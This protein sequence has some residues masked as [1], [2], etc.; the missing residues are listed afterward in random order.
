MRRT[1][2]GIVLLSL[3]LAATACK[4]GE[5]NM[6]QA[7]KD[8]PVKVVEVKEETREVFLEYI[9]TVHAD[10]VKKLSFKSSGRISDVYVKKGQS[11]RKGD[12]LA[13]LDTGDLELA[14]KASEAQASAAKAQYEKAL[15]GAT[16][17]DINNAALNLKKAREAYEFVKDN[18]VKIEALYNEGAVS[19]QD[20]D[21]AKL[22]LDVKEAEAR[23]A[24]ELYNQVKGGAR[25]E[26]KQALLSQYRQA[27][28]DA[29]HKR[30]L[31][32]DAVMR[33]GMDGYVLD[34]LFKKD[35]MAAAGYP[36][37]VLRGNGRIIKVG[38]SQK[39]VEKL[40]VGTKVKIVAGE[41]VISAEVS[42]IDHIPDESTMTYNVEILLDSESLSIGSIVDVKF[43]IGEETGI[44]I[45]V[46]AI[47]SDGKNYVFTVRDG[48]AERREIT[49]GSPDGGLVKVKGLNGNELLVVEGFMKLRDGS[50]VIV[51]ER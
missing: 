51:L 14:L 18:F 23:Q 38:V 13:A 48:K 24:E 28:A 27:L 10:E 47:M 6:P 45:P 12:L 7:Q 11:V 50:R 17:E 16:E 22:E 20:Y 42:G 35:E 39:D 29:E 3:A 25:E 37:I 21:R 36:V 32:E 46:S 19:R 26:D 5:T 34:V 44:W 30:S 4:T 15:K 43:I 1:V 33:S 8:I 2:F 49:A 40:D 31:L 41:S 9:G